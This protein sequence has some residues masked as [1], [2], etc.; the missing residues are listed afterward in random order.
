MDTSRLRSRSA[1]AL[2]TASLMTTLLL[3]ILV[4]AVQ[5]LYDRP[6]DAAQ[7]YQKI[8]ETSP[9]S[10]EARDASRQLHSMGMKTPLSDQ[11]PE[12]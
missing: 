11:T 10:R 4:V 5:R 7:W 12:T 6:A 9:Q 1:L 8:I 3:G 2:L